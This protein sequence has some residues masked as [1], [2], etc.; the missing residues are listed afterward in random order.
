MFTQNALE[1]RSAMED[2]YF[3]MVRILNDVVGD[4]RDEEDKKDEG[5]V[6]LF[7]LSSSLFLPLYLSVVHSPFISFVFFDC[8]LPLL[9]RV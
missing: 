1:G 7:R 6:S 5:R 3:M 2:K 8:S 4:K 9:L